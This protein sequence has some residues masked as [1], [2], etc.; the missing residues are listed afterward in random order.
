MNV[1]I[2]L[3]MYLCVGLA[4]VP[5]MASFIDKLALILVRD[6]RQLVARTKGKTA[7]FTP[8]GKREAGETDEQ[9]LVRECKEELS[10]DLLTHT[11]QPYGVFEAQAFGKPEGTMVRM[12]CYTSDYAGTLTPSNEIEE[13][14]WID[15]TCPDEDLSVTGVM[16]LKD[17]HAKKL[18]D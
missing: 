18:V 12:T 15:S 10:I 1:H 2:D 6:R 5:T 13:I 4:G 11:I 7:F 9:A 8:G 16:I 14:R 3:Q 17:L